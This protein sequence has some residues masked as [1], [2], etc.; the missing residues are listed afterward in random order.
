MPAYNFQAQF[1]PKVAAGQKRQTIRKCRKRPTVVGDI[2]Y[3]YRGMRTKEAKLLLVQEC[4][5][6]IQIIIHRD[7]VEFPD[8]LRGS[9]Y[10][11]LPALLDDFAR[12]DGFR[13]FA[14]MRDW[15]MRTYKKL[16]F[17]GEII[18]W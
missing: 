8:D 1:A 16:P 13:N 6:V 5:E 17:T 15:F 12:Q 4:K 18:Q 10:I 3:L 9:R 14:A 2:L 7:T 11:T